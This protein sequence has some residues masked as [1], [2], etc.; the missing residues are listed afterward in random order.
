MI[1]EQ[2]EYEPLSHFSYAIVSN[3]EMAV[4]DPQ[5]DP[6]EYYAFAVKHKAKIT[7]VIETHPHAD[8]ISCHLQI[9]QETGATIY[10]SEKTGAEYPHSSF[11]DGDEI[12]LGNV[13][14]SAINTPGHSPDSI[15][16]KASN[17]EEIAL[18][19]GDTLFVGDIGRPDLREK[20]GN[21]KAKRE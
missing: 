2:F 11:D 10:T 8:F 18:F 1:I 21:L 16:V 20:S 4:I 5:R 19:T 13:K 7:T 6:I 12:Q 14:L 15:T 9:H 17:D 3:G